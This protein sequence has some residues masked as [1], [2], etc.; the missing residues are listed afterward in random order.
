MSVT[1]TF[2]RRTVG[3]EPW[4]VEG[5]QS[6]AASRGD[7]DRVTREALLRLVQLYDAWGQSAKAAPK[8]EETQKG[9]V[10]GTSESAVRSGAETPK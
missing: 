1:S 10:P 2:G 3:A 8:L 4:L 9:T 5:Y 6:L 7:G